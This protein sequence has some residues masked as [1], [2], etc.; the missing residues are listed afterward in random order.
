MRAGDS[1]DE[2]DCLFGDRPQDHVRGGSWREWSGV[3][4]PAGR[5]WKGPLQA[6]GRRR[7]LPCAAVGRLAQEGGGAH[8]QAVAAVPQLPPADF[9]RDGRRPA[10]RK[11]PVQKYM[12]RGCGRRFSALPRLKGR[13]APSGTIADALSQVSNGMSLAKAANE[14]S[15]K[16]EPFWPQRNTKSLRSSMDKY[17]KQATPNIWHTRIQNHFDPSPDAL[18]GGDFCPDFK[19]R[20][21]PPPEDGEPGRQRLLFGVV[22]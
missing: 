18:D 8:F 11:G 14:L 15:R 16:R 5:I 13:H 20:G 3:R 4:L 2:M 7:F 22:V 21:M 12:C 17:P 6:R 9:A 1:R 19:V 10:K